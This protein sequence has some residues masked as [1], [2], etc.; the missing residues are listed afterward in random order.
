MDS[1]GAGSWHE[2]RI[3]YE[4][5][6]RRLRALSSSQIGLAWTEGAGSFDV[7]T[8]SFSTGP[9]TG[10][11]PITVSLSAP[12]N[13][14]SLTSATTITATASS[15]AGTIA[16]VQFAV[17]G[18]NVGAEDLSSPF[19]ITWD[20]TTAS[21]G[22]HYLSA[23]ARDSTGATNYANPVTVTRDGAVPTVTITAPLNGDAV[24]GASVVSQ[25]MP[26]T[27]SAWSASSS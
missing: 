14:A 11:S 17:D 10:P 1:L 13:G 23:T 7:F 21:V 18:V 4:E 3:A 25:R 15:T 8:T 26:R 16:G 19:S 20:P 6:A 24:G 5:L 12:L 9:A 2:Q 27:T 22:T